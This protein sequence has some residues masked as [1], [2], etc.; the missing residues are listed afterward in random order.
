MAEQ[1]S[2]K[3]YWTLEI[4]ESSFCD[5][6]WFGIYFKKIFKQ[7][8]GIILMILTL[9]NINNILLIVLDTKFYV[10]VIDLVSLNKNIE[11]KIQFTNPLVKCLK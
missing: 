6:C 11:V 5:L 1:V 10:L 7:L 9:I 4:I 8:I 3:I 2:N